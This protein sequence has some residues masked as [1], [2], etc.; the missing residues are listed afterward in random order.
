MPGT[1]NRIKNATNKHVIFRLNKDMKSFKFY[2]TSMYI[3]RPYYNIHY[4]ICC[5]SS[6]TVL[7]ADIGYRIDEYRDKNSA[8]ILHV[9]YS[10]GWSVL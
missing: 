1:A 10:I 6:F 5:F 4:G 3:T 7:S 8:H 9:T 2:E